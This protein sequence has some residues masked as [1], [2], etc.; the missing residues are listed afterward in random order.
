MFQQK[1]SVLDFHGL[2]AYIESLKHVYFG[3]SI[4][5]WPRVFLLIY[6]ILIGF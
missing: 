5:I 1:S 2:F 6:I 3:T 4:V